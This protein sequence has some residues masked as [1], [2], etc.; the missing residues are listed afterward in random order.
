MTNSDPQIDVAT[1]QLDKLKLEV[2]KIQ[3]EIR[4]LSRP[5]IFHPSAYI[6]ILTSLIALSGV[7]TNLYFA[8]QQRDQAVAAQKKAESETA[9]QELYATGLRKALQENPA[10][11]L[12]SVNIRFRGSL[13]REVITALQQDLVANGFVAS[14]PLRT[15]AVSQSS[16][17]YYYPDD[18][19]L[20]EQVLNQATEFFKQRN[21]PISLQPLTS[22]APAT[23]N[24]PGTIQ[25]DVFHSCE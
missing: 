5:P 21:C 22:P 18:K 9:G 7:M 12:R 15:A 10:A 23:S 24:K 14:P 3:L 20:A 13:S 8:N 16:V 17:T 19:P 25:L 11:L 1:T 6:P 2:Q 4:N